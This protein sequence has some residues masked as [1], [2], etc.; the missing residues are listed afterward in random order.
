MEVNLPTARSAALPSGTIRRARGL[1][2]V[3]RP[4]GMSWHKPQRHLVL[5]A[6]LT[7]RAHSRVF[8]CEIRQLRLEG[9]Y[10]RDLHCISFAR[11]ALNALRVAVV[12]AGSARSSLKY[13]Y[14]P[15]ETRCFVYPRLW[16]HLHRHPPM[17]AA[18]GD[19][20]RRSPTRRLTAVHCDYPTLC[21]VSSTC[22]QFRPMTSVP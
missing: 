19:A 8:S 6:D 5:L 7:T 14:V 13:R 21:A 9:T 18:L 17:L 3:A 12:D 10:S 22:R 4:I 20:T 16:M 2:A 11:L 15:W 1:C